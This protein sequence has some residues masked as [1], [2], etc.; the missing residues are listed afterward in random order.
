MCIIE[1]V[2][3]NESY[4]QAKQ[5]AKKSTSRRRRGGKKITSKTETVNETENTDVQQP[6][7]VAAEEVKTPKVD[8]K[9]EDA[10]VVEQ[11]KAAE[12]TDT[13][14]EEKSEDKE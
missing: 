12:K 14:K 9:K 2:D 1:L 3:Y 13:K 10:K 5:A 4:T 11:P 8:N 7:A 6:E